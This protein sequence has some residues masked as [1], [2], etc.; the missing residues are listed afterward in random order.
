MISPRHADSRLAISVTT[1]P[2]VRLSLAKH[3][4]ANPC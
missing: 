1:V 4:V 3:V 2:T